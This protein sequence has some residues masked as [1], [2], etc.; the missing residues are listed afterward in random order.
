MNFRKRVNRL[1]GSCTKNFGESVTYFPKTGGAIKIRGIF[2]NEHETVD[3]DTEQV[4]SSNTPTLGVN[5]NDLSIEMKNEDQVQIRNIKHKVIDVQ[6]DGQG[7]AILVLHKLRHDEK[8]NKT[9]DST[10]P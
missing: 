9:E 10:S 5:L 8:I 1:L 6:E 4:I 7:G 3:P 2:N